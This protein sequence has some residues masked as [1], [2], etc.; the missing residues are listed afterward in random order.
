MRRSGRGEKMGRNGV[1]SNLSNLTTFFGPRGGVYQKGSV[2]FPKKAQTARRNVTVV[3]NYRPLPKNVHCRSVLPL[4]KL[5][6]LLQSR[7]IS[8]R[9]TQI[10]Q[11]SWRY[12][13]D[14][15]V[16]SHPSDPMRDSACS[17]LSIT[18]EN[19]VVGP[20]WNAMPRGPSPVRRVAQ[21]Y[22]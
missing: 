12:R 7:H 16:R 13:S 21:C 11:L 9:Q 6:A 2:W 22:V 3:F 14:N 20:D 5:P 17:C 18:T 10:T 8:K 1:E 15:I 4:G 19:S